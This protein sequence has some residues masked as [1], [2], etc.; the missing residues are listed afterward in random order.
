MDNVLES[1]F[2]CWGWKFFGLRIGIDWFEIFGVLRILCVLKIWIRNIFVWV[3]EYF[4][5]LKFKD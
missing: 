4:N 3:N 1:G 2:G 5:H